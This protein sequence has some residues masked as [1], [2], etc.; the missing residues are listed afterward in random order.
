MHEEN[1]DWRLRGDSQKKR[2]KKRRNGSDYKREELRA[3]RRANPKKP[4]LSDPEGPVRIQLS[5]GSRLR[6]LPKNSDLGKSV[7]QRHSGRIRRIWV[8]PCWLGKCSPRKHSRE[9]SKRAI[10]LFLNC[11]RCLKQAEKQGFVQDFIDNPY[12]LRQKYLPSGRV[13][14]ETASEW[15]VKDEIESSKCTGKW[16][17]VAERIKKRKTEGR[18]RF[19][20]CRNG[21][22][23]SEEIS[24]L[25]VDCDF[26]EIPAQPARK[27]ARSLDKGFYFGTEQNILIE[28]PKTLKE[29]E[30]DERYRCGMIEY[31]KYR[32]EHLIIVPPSKTGVGRNKWTPRWKDMSI[33]VADQIPVRVFMCTE[34]ISDFFDWILRRDLEW[35]DLRFLVNSKLGHNRWEAEI[36]GVYWH[37]QN[38]ALITGQA[39]GI[40]PLKDPKACKK[41]KKMLKQKQEAW[42]RISKPFQ[43]YDDWHLDEVPTEDGSTEPVS[44]DEDYSIAVEFPGDEDIRLM[45]FPKG[46][47]WA[48]FDTFVNAKLGENKWIAAFDDGFGGEP[49]QD[50]SRVPRPGQRV[51]VFWVKEEVKEEEKVARE[52]KIQKFTQ[53]IFSRPRSLKTTEETMSSTDHSTEAG[54]KSDPM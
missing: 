6:R 53:A 44:N 19:K 38:M 5:E 42:N 13:T 24:Y 31:M 27:R 49:W 3:G 7:V 12:F 29:T 21:V 16:T 15:K 43:G 34:E 22:E 39:I 25:T 36:G 4:K 20:T 26:Q 9:Q 1:V 35:D 54:G 52:E 33:K 11:A 32:N 8:Q 10:R 40:T 30:E 23:N 45:R 48:F 41:S 14:P 50:N 46:N 2:R 17:S 28:G 47:E 18:R 51:G 37:G